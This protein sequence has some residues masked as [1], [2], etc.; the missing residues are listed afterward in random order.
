MTDLVAKAAQIRRDLFEKAIA[1]DRGHV[2][3]ALSWVEIAVALFYG[4]MVLKRDRFVLSKT[5]GHLTL[6]VI[7]ED[8]GLTPD[9]LMWP[10]WPFKCSGSL[11]QG[12]SIAAGMALAAKLDGSSRRVFCMVGDAELHEGAIWEAA[13]FAGHHKLSN[14]TLIVDNNRQCCADFTS[15]VLDMGRIWEKFFTFGWT[16][17]ESNG[18]HIENV[19][20]FLSMRSLQPFC[21]VASTIKGK[22]IPFMEG[23]VKWHH[24][25]PHGDELI[26]ARRAL[27]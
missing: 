21:L 24:Q 19:S 9:Y 4:V 11:G 22:G 16:C 8:L 17:A 27:A 1:A 18:H 2:P 15:G 13:M 20:E 7:L 23:N 10:G 25:L 14:L 5:H 12:L 3:P 6:D 26:E